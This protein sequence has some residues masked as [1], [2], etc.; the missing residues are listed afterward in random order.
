MEKLDPETTNFQ[1]C[2]AFI[3][4]QRLCRISLQTYNEWIDSIRLG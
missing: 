3:V 2:D 4:Q 1:R